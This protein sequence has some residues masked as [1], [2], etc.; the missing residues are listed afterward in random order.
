MSRR[1]GIVAP[2][3]PARPRPIEDRPPSLPGA[4]GG[5]APHAGKKVGKADDLAQMI[6]DAGSPRGGRA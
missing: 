2:S 3:E 1:G 4:R 6:Q 5:D